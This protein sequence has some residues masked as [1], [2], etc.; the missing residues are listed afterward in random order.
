AARVFPHFNIP[1]SVNTKRQRNDLFDA[2]TNRIRERLGVSVIDM[3]KGLREIN[4]RLKNNEMIA[5]LT[6]QYAGGR[7]II[8]DF[9]GFPATHWKGAA[10]LSLKLKVPIVVGYALRNEDERIVFTFDSMIYHDCWDDTEENIRAVIDEVNRIHEQY[11]IAHPH[12]WFWVHKRW[13]GTGQQ[14]MK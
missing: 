14:G 10:K 13:K 12:Q 5:I 9:L 7:G 6:D 3:Y 4:T 2:Y 8:S 11:I 1:V